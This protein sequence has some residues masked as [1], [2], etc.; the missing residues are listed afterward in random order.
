MAECEARATRSGFEPDFN[1]GIEIGGGE[2]S[3]APSLNDALAG[4]ELEIAAGDVAV[5]Y[6]EFAAGLRGYARGRAGHRGMAL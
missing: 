4:N 3:G 5:P 1:L 6:G 2:L